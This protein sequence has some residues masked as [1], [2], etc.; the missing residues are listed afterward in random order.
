MGKLVSYAPVADLLD[1]K[2]AMT[3]TAADDIIA[4]QSA[5]V[6][7]A[8]MGILV[9]NADASVGT[10]VTIR[11]GTTAKIVGYAAA[12]GGF[13]MD[14]NGQPLFVGTAATAVTA[15]CTTNSSDTDVFIWGH[16]VR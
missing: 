9:T 12:G 16:K 10:K 6:K 8:V 15:I 5:G 14:G 1:G 4:A 13:S 11:D 3:D 2:S 7:I